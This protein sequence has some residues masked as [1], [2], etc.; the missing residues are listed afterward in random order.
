MSQRALVRTH[1]LTWALVG[2]ALYLLG[3]LV[4][5]YG[6]RML[7]K[8]LPLLALI[9]WTWLEAPR[10]EGRLTAGALALGLAGDM[11]LEASGETFLFGLV[12]FLLGHLVY[13]AAFSLSARA[14]RPALAIPWAIYIVAVYLVLGEKLGEMAVPVV[15]YMVAISA[16]AWRAS[17]WSAAGGAALW[18]LPGATLF[19]F[20]D[21]LIAVDRFVTPLDGAGPAIMITYWLAQ[22]GLAA[23]VVLSAA[24][25][26]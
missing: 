13:I 21:T 20:S 9:A 24:A 2:V 7:A 16:M 14:L 15:L 8:P 6:L 1:L 12:A 3:G 22:A 23:S 11:L 25:A 10:R 4:D 26:Q 18:A 17:A 5:S 19:V